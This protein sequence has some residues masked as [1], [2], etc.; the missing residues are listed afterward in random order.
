MALKIVKKKNPKEIIPKKIAIITILGTINSDK[1]LYTKEKTL[2]L[3]I[4]DGEYKNMFPLLYDSF[5]NVKEATLIPIYTKKAIEIQK[6]VLPSVD[7]KENGYEI[8]EEKFDEIFNTINSILSDNSFTD[9]I[10]DISHGF[11]HLPI[12]ATVSMIISNFQDSSKVKNILFTKEIDKFKHYEIIDLKDYLEIANISFVL[13]TFD[14]NYTVAHH[15][16]SQKYSSLIKSLNN[17]SND[18]MAL[19][20]SNL[21]NISLLTLI[22]ELEKIEDISIKYMAEQLKQNLLEDFSYEDKMY[23]TF[24]KI[25]KN[26][27]EKNYILLSLSLLYESIRIYIKTIIKKNEKAVVLKIEEFYKNDLYKLGDFF[28][29]LYKRDYYYLS[30]KE[31]STISKFEYEKL[32]LA[33]KRNI[34]TPSLIKDIEHTRNDL[35]HANS[36]EKFE[37]IKQKVSTLIERYNTSY[38]LNILLN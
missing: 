6:S 1:A 5:K 36:K 3:D 14:D 7:I 19:N 29:K 31:K 38:N 15:I 37:Q 18:I 16:N 33:Y 21:H 28:K 9:F 35:S 24:Y 25:S 27:F 11:R 10:V 4:K 12:L 32:Q 2:K 20:L 34:T 17:F 30:E 23:L 8:D 26:L 22:K 13:N